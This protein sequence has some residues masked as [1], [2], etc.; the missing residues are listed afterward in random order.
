M[1]PLILVAAAAANPYDPVFAAPQ[2]PVPPHEATATISADGQYTLILLPELAWSAA[3]LSVEGA[4]SME[5][6]PAADG[7]RVEVSG[8]LDRTGTLVVELMAVT[9]DAQGVSWSFEVEPEL[10]PVAPPDR[11][12][13]ADKKRGF[14]P[15]RSGS[16][17]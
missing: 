4:G 9:P 10:L 6:G 17:A 12:P 7:G 2:V 1:W 11:L 14:W 15:F 13:A 5:L 16:G 8:V 3:E